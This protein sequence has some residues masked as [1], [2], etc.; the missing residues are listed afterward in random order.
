M[1]TPPPIAAERRNGERPVVVRVSSVLLH[2]DNDWNRK[3]MATHKKLDDDGL[4][5]Q[6]FLRR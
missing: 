5:I 1:A 2:F 6:D 3:S 4:A